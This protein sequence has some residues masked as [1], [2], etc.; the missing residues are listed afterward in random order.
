MSEVVAARRSRRVAR[1]MGAVLAGVLTNIVVVGA[2]DAA[3]RA[4]GMFPAIFEPMSDRQWVLRSRIE[5]SL[6]WLAALLP[7]G[8]RRRGLC[9]T[10]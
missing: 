6:R 4:A 8:L 9:G 5:S 10:P 1:S 3:M 7:P 2:I